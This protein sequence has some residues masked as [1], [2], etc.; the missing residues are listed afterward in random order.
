MAGANGPHVD[1][2]QPLLDSDIDHRRPR[3]LTNTR[4]WFERPFTTQNAANFVFLNGGMNVFLVFVPLGL[5]AGPLKWNPILVSIF[6]FLAIIPLSAVVSES[7]DKLADDFGDLFGALINAT[8]GNAVEMIVGILAVMHRDP[9]F[10]QS[11]MLGSILSDILFVLG[12]CFF[13]AAWQRPILKLN[14]AVTDTLSSLMLITAVALILPTALYSTFAD[15]AKPPDLDGQI[16]AFSRGTA[17]VLLVLY[18][19]YLYFELVSHKHLFD[20]PQFNGR[21]SMDYTTITGVPTEQEIRRLMRQ[22]TERDMEQVMEPEEQDDEESTSPS[23]MGNLITTAILICSG[24]AIMAC[25]HLLLNSV[26]DT[27]DA[28]GISRTFIATI[29]LPIASNAPE[30]ATVLKSYNTGRVDFAVG[31]I[32]GS[33]LQIALFVTPVLVALGW[34]IN[35]AMDLYFETF[36]TIT[37]FFSILLVNHLLQD[38]KYTYM[39]G[40]VLVGLYL[41]IAVAFFLRDDI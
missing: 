3:D 12:C 40:T 11:M 27:S 26:N 34:I 6:N 17:L 15:S 14:T 28:T 16:L 33:I 10:A 39:H 25:A 22:D 5:I 20:P 32:V 35:R 38:K 2:A 9:K 31:V 13:S 30:C 8:F 23:T 4:A 24:G 21:A 1:E 36:Q 19:V 18:L 41:V 37:L 29:L 7:S